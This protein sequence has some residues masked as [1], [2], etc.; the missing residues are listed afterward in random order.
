MR[1]RGGAGRVTHFLRGGTRAAGRAEAA[2]AVPDV[3]AGQPSEAELL[4]EPGSAGVGGA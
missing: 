3:G 1:L 2:D 4:V